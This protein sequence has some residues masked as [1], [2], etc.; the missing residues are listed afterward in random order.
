MVLQEDLGGRAWQDCWKESTADSQERRVQERGG[1]GS[2]GTRS[3]QRGLGAASFG[4]CT[5]KAH[6]A[7]QKQSLN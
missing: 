3:G 5:L 6:E 4:G 1:E 7:L 2:L